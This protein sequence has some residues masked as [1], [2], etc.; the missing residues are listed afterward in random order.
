MKLKDLPTK[1]DFNAVEKGK[2]QTWVEKG[3]FTAGDISKKPFTI[4]IPRHYRKLHL[5]HV[6]Y[7]LQVSLPGENGRVSMFYLSEWTMRITTQTRL[8]L[9]LERRHFSL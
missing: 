4:V 8:K 1:Y 3:Y 5:R 7:N 2:Y 9:N 6:R